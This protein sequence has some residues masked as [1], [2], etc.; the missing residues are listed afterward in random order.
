LPPFGWKQKVVS[1]GKP[2]QQYGLRRQ[3][4][5]VVKVSTPVGIRELEVVPTTFRSLLARMTIGPSRPVFLQ[6][7]DLPQATLSLAPDEV[8]LLKPGPALRNQALGARRLGKAESSSPNSRRKGDVIGWRAR[9]GMR[10]EIEVERAA[11]PVPNEFSKRPGTAAA[12]RLLYE[13]PSDWDVVSSRTL[14]ERV[15]RFALSDHARYE[16]GRKVTI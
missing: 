12:N 9:D 1:K 14:E 16:R 4:D 7:C 3:A 13:A 15:N 11:S 2:N 8:S 10:E 5:S 6:Q